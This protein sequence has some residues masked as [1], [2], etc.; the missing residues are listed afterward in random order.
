[1]TWS[2]YDCKNEHTRCCISCAAGSNY[3]LKEKKMKVIVEAEEGNLAYEIKKA[4]RVGEYIG[5]KKE[6]C[7]PVQE[8]WITE[9]QFNELY[10]RCISWVHYTDILRDAKKRGW[11]KSSKT[12]KQKFEE[13]AIKP[14]LVDGSCSSVAQFIQEIVDAAREAIEESEKK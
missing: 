12:A 7:E 9:E 13:L 10:H 14:I 5:I 2:C 8:G 1:M 11:I 6:D 3:K 4:Y